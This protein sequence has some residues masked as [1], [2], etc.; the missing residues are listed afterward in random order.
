MKQ[1]NDIIVTNK[2]H[3]EKMVNEGC[4]FT[5]PWL[6]L[7]TNLINQ[8]VKG[9]L[10]PVPE[11]L[12]VMYPTSV[13]S[14]IKGKDVLCLAAGGGQ[15]SVVFSLLGA[16]VIVVDLAE[17]QL[18]ADQKAA[19]HY[20]YE[21]DTIQ[22]DMRDLSRLGNNNFDLVYGTGMSY[23]PDVKQVYSEV[24][25]VLRTGG[26]YRVDFT[27]PATEFVD[28]DD[29]DG[30]G[31][32]ITKP[33]TERIRRLKDGPIEFRHTLSIIFNE[34][35]ATGLSIKHV[36]EAPTYIQHVQASPGSWEHWLTYVTKFAIVARKD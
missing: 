12:L 17:G 9:Q 33:Y 36:Q 18:K 15:Q 30:K 3:W 4:S 8:Y 2:Q 10:D 35:L 6:N 26:K 11:E 27:N 19:A 23:V 20:G 32:R 14:D 21:I 25:R 29:W 1:Q 7:D 13:L 34:L 5:R 28:C 16:H 22:G 31:Y 24:A